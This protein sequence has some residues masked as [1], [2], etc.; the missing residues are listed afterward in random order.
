MEFVQD[1]CMLQNNFLS[2]TAHSPLDRAKSIQI[3]CLSVQMEGSLHTD[4][5]ENRICWK[6][7]DYPTSGHYLTEHCMEMSS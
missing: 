6:K 1:A 7:E 3:V 4:L 5:Y 2:K